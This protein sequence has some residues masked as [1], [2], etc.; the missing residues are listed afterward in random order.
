MVRGGLPPLNELE[1]IRMNWVSIFFRRHT[2]ELEDIRMHWNT[3]NELGFSL[4]LGWKTYEWIGRHTNELGFRL[5]VGEKTYEWIG[6]HTNELEDIRM[7][8]GSDIFFLE[9]IRSYL[10]AIIRMWGSFFSFF[11][12]VLTCLCT[13]A[14][15]F[16]HF[17]GGAKGRP[18]VPPSP[19][20]PLLLFRG[21]NNN[22]SIS[23]HYY[24]FR[25]III[26]IDVASLLL[27]PRD[28]NNESKSIHYYYFREIIIMVRGGVPPSNP[29]NWK[30][31]E[32]TAK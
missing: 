31:Y 3:H 7:N 22:E 24:Y 30:T 10:R 9:G 28:N 20:E 25:E 14:L 16:S 21:N 26:I 8:S 32:W 29:M 23:I 12:S 11:F 1:D 18:A 6:R 17:R 15:H 19:P 13:K 2:N 5:F 27:F 4:F